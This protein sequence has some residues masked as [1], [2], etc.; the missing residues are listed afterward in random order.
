MRYLTLF[1]FEI[2]HAYYADGHSPDFQIEPAPATQK[3]LNACRCILKPLPSGLNV[4]AALDDQNMP[5]IALPAD[6]LF[7]F[8]LRLQNPDFPLFTDLADFNRMDAP[9]YSN[10]S[11]ATGGDLSLGSRQAWSSERF[12]VQQPSSKE[13]FTLGE[14]PAGNLK[15]SDFTVQGLKGKASLKSYTQD[16]KIITIN[17]ASSE[18]GQ[19]FAVTYPATPELER[20]VFA[21][22]EIR[23]DPTPADLSKSANLFRITFAPKE[24]RWKYYVITDKSDNK[25]SPPALEDGDKAVVFDAADL[26][27]L[28]AHP[29]PSDDVAT[30]LMDQYPG[31][32]HF[33]FISKALIPCQKTARKNI[34]FQL[35]GE[36]VI[37]VLPNPALENYRIDTS[38]SSE[39]Y[40]LYQ[41]IKYFTH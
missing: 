14:H 9:L 27:D 3:L 1:R 35:N 18:Q 16:T 5:L 20:G 28:S 36:K 23:Y 33:R 29:D 13:S 6:P 21:D 26:T 17:T 4:L 24:A 41:I 32:Q 11:A 34:Q 2:E 40:S 25:T 19:P 31:L 12:A 15:A 22:V 7:A 8:H 10:A 39:E 37:N 38:N 30:S